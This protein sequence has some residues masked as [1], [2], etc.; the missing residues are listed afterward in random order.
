MAEVKL[1]VLIRLATLVPKHTEQ[2]LYPSVSRDLNIV[3]DESVRWAAV[4]ELVDASGGEHLECVEYQDTYRDPE[5][6]GGGKKSLLFSIRLRW[7]SGTL[8][9][10][11]ADGVRDNIVAKLAEKL[12]GQ[13]RA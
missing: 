13:L 4:A 3:V 2:S 6:L 1:S 12:G 8:T 5:R 9:R 11:E 10:E 7:A